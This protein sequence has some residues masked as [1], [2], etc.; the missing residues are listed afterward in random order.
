MAETSNK[1]YSEPRMAEVTE[2]DGYERRR[3]SSRVEDAIL[4]DCHFLV[5]VHRINELNDAYIQS[6]K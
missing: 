1:I 3:M 4:C 2:R 6:C 5:K